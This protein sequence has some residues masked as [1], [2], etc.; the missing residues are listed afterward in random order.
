MVK[1]EAEAREREKIIAELIAAQKET[2]REAQREKAR[3]SK[4]GELEEAYR[5]LK[6]EADAMREALFVSEEERAKLHRHSLNHVENV[7]PPHP[8]L[9]TVLS[10]LAQS[11]HQVRQLQTSYN[12]AQAEVERIRDEASEM[13]GTVGDLQG[14]M[15]SLAQEVS[16][17]VR[18]AHNVIAEPTQSARDMELEQLV[19]SVV[20]RISSSFQVYLLWNWRSKARRWNRE[21]PLQG[22][23]LRASLSEDVDALRNALR[24]SAQESDP[25]SVP[26]HQKLGRS[27]PPPGPLPFWGSRSSAEFSEYHPTPSQGPLEGLLRTSADKRASVAPRQEPQLSGMVQTL[28]KQVASLRDQLHLHPIPAYVGVSEQQGNNC[29]GPTTAMPISTAIDDPPDVTPVHEQHLKAVQERKGQ[30]LATRAKLVQKAKDAAAQ[31]ASPTRG[32]AIRYQQL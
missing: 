24:L 32:P 20:T 19:K 9:G 13:K 31:L 12:E 15:G 30:L 28:N 4:V 7:A 27:S 23:A 14:A 29:R 5:A 21:G 6:K 18:T 17:A 8:Q 16:Q 3:A 2:E 22:E 11:R 10:E 26:Q 25:Q 1:L